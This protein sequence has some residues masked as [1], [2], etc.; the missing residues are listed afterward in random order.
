MKK[1]TFYLFSCLVMSAM[2]FTG[3]S[4][5]GEGDASATKAKAK[6]GKEVINTTEI[7][8]ISFEEAQ[9]KMK[10]NPKKIFVDVYTYWCGPCKKMNQNTFTHPGIIKYVNQNYYPVKFNAQHETQVTYNGNPYANP[11]YDHNKGQYRRNGVHQLSIAMGVRAYPTL[12]F[13]DE[14][15]NKIQGVPGYKTPQQ[16][17]PMLAYFAGEDY[18]K[19]Q[20]ESFQ[21]GFVSSL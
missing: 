16:L 13:I 20:W 11:T 10:D 17:E 9:E 1:I 15:L 14:N 12:V 4:K 7:E 5:G 8:W 19:T 2:I 6:K 18:K 3:C 21:A